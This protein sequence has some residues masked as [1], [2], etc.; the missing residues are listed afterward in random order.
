MRSSD[1]QI[2]LLTA[3][4]LRFESQIVLISPNRCSLEALLSLEDEDYER[5]DTFT[6]TLEAETGRYQRTELKRQRSKRRRRRRG[7]FVSRDTQPMR[8]YGKAALKERHRLE[9]WVKINQH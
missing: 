7:R 8:G 1:H 4:C 5:A 6:Q 3:Q 9:L 2:P